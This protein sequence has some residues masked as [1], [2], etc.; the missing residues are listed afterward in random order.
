V[1]DGG[2]WEQDEETILVPHAT[3]PLALVTVWLCHCMLSVCRRPFPR[4]PQ[5]LMRSMVEEEQHLHA[6]LRSTSND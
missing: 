4:Y 6:V 5:P 3:V 1:R 2:V